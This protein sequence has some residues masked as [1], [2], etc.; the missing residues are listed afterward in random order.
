MAS[1]TFF[2]FFLFGL[3]STSAICGTCVP[4]VFFIGADLC[5]AIVILGFCLLLLVNFR[6]IVFVIY[7][8][9]F[10]LF[11]Y[12]AAFGFGYCFLLCR[13]CH[14]FSC[15]LLYLS[16]ILSQYVVFFE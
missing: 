2:G 15:R 4:C 11:L 1:F 5:L 6:L 7:R 8:E 12:C 10:L 9:F 14:E 16:H 3:L 13:V